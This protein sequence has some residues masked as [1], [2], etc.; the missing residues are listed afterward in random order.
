MKKNTKNS[1]QPIGL[2]YGIICETIPGVFH[3]RDTPQNQ[4][5]IQARE[6]VDRLFINLILLCRESFI[7]GVRLS[8]T[9]TFKACA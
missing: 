9:L 2:I 4:Y 1:Q 6:T 7:S 8:S 5:W 3:L